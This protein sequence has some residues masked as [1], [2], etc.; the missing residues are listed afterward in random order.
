MSRS[1]NAP[2]H[3]SLLPRGSKF[4]GASENLFELSWTN[5]HRNTA[6]CQ[7]RLKQ[8]VLPTRSVQKSLILHCNRT[9]QSHP[10]SMRINRKRK[11]VPKQPQALKSE[12]DCNFVH[13]LWS[14]AGKTK[15]E[16]ANWH[17]GQGKGEA[18]ALSSFTTR[19]FMG[20]ISSYMVHVIIPQ[21]ILHDPY[22]S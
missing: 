9:A 2:R 5:S 8:S 18:L 14:H 21:R 7:N 10:T 22:M 15:A 4:C 13:D 19:S 11:V 17:N 12:V 1:N 20:Y 3:P 16:H 6:A